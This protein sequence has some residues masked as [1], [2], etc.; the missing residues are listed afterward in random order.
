MNTALLVRYLE[1][2]TV[3]QGEGAG[4]R[5][6][7]FPWE[8]KFVRGAF[9]ADG[10]A[11]LSV[12]RGNGKTALLAGVAT[13]FIDGPLRQPRAEVVVVAS[14][15]N[16]AKIGFDHAKH[17]LGAKLADRE[18]W[19]V[20]DSDQNA[21]IEHRPT[22]AKLRT[23]GCD[24]RRAHGLAPALILADE[25]SQWEHTKSEKMTA[26]LRTAMGKIPAAR[27]VALGTRPED[28]NHWFE[29]A[30]RGGF[31]YSQSHHADR[32]DD[33]FKVSTWHKA[34]PS[35]RYMPA[36]RKR[37]E[38]EAREAKADPSKLAG[39]KALRLN[40]G[41][42]DTLQ[43]YLIEVEQWERIQ[44]HGG[45]DRHGPYVLGLDL[46][47]S[48]AMSAA[49]SYWP[50]SG[51]LDTLACFPQIPSLAER[52]LHDG[53]GREYC[54]MADRGELIIR[55]KRVSDVSALLR[56]VADRW[57]HPV[58]IATDR[59]REKE[60]RD[61]LDD[62]G[63]PLARLEIRGQGFKDGAAD[64]RAFR[65]ACLGDR[66][67]PVP[68][69]LLTSAMREARVMIE[70]STGHAKLAKGSEG[71]R[72]VRARDDAAAAGIIAVALGVRLWNERRPSSKSVH[73]GAV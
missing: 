25:P 39:F 55:G 63:F 16:Q 5:L 71:G 48:A 26:A 68:S 36:L 37:I 10:D 34:N 40:Q 21:V 33:P 60:L 47:T 35:M 28:T 61:A 41:V 65:S 3:T 15:F 58:A 52:G 11:C 20:S 54:D 9:T 2:L 46:G 70:K 59:W 44:G 50:E 57:G 6:K 7:L 23:I 27:M 22:G 53:V 51:T 29:V 64:V 66:V 73:L 31:A 45:A 72:R 1:S 12:A 14:S 42:A 43:D 56:E 62:V 24:P 38:A 19:R 67:A 18:T 4:H 30:L 69:L 32:K 49:A 17:F 13:A 8:R